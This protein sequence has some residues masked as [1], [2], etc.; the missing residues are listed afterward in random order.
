[1]KALTGIDPTLECV[2]IASTAMK[3]WRRMFL[4]KN[5]IAV[6]PHKGWRR[7]QQNQSLEAIQWLE[8]E[9]FKQGGG[10]R[11]SMCLVFAVHNLTW[12]DVRPV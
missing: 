4:E 6:E 11:V 12:A 1:M 8:F 9:N 3:V 5:L 10:I 7:N 2:T